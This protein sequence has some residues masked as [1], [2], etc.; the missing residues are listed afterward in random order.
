MVCHS[1]NSHPIAAHRAV[2]PAFFAHENLPSSALSGTVRTECCLKL[3]DL[4]KTV[5]QVSIV[6]TV[7]PVQRQVR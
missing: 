6:S 5:V 4:H 3:C 1:S 7:N 2:H